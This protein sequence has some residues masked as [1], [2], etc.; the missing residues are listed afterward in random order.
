MGELAESKLPLRH[1]R[2]LNAERRPIE[3]CAVELGFSAA[4]SQFP[5]QLSVAP[6]DLLQEC[7]IA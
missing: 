3:R 1:P 5:L 4:A 2:P 6:D 7:D